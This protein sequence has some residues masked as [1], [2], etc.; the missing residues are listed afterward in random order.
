[1]AQGKRLLRSRDGYV[2]G[3]CMGIARHWDVDP[4]V[5]RILFI[6][7]TLATFGVGAAVY[8]IMWITIPLEPEKPRPYE[9]DPESVVSSTFGSVDCSQARGACSGP[10][11]RPCQSAGKTPPEPPLRGRASVTGAPGARVG[12]ANVGTAQA[13]P[14]GRAYT[15]APAGTMS[16][17]SSAATKDAAESSSVEQCDQGPSRGA[18][19]GLCVGL[20]VLFFVVASTAPPFLP[21]TQWWQFWP[22]LLLFAGLCLMV[23][24]FRS[25]HGAAWNA[26]G[27]V[28]I[29]V[30]ATLLPM[31]LGAL[32]WNTLTVGLAT[33]WILPVAGIVLFVAGLARHASPLLFGGALCVLLFC[34]LTLMLCAIPSN[35][36]VV[37]MPDGH[38]ITL[39]ENDAVQATSYASPDR[40]AAE[41]LAES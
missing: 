5:V 2:A 38:S 22:L 12:S 21:G 33:L 1:M 34:V 13:Q 25:C 18:R 14:S 15:Y 6:L 16:A 37:R 7:V 8:L 39:L 11:E 4:I 17:S 20:L 10:S 9:V 19:I 40:V 36:V 27:V 32:S 23:I 41:I 3:V 26:F 35:Q 31:T 29:C 24:H 30:G 28:L